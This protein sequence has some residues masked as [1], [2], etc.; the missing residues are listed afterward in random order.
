MSDFPFVSYPSLLYRGRGGGGGGGSGNAGPR[1]VD[2]L[3]AME[4][5]N[6]PYNLR[7]LASW[8][9][10]GLIINPTHVQVSYLAIYVSWAWLLLSETNP[11]ASST[12]VCIYLSM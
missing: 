6:G 10:L 1:R 8:A 5:A 2:A 3:I 12:Y 9:R 11:P 4:V 7:E